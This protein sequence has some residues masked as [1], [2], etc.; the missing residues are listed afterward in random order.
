[1]QTDAVAG[2]SRHVICAQSPEAVMQFW[3]TIGL[4][5]VLSA[6]GLT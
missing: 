5:L 2:S 3:I 6:L 1:M 4:I